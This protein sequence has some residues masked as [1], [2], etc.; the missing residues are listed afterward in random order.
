ML[1]RLA[2][3]FWGQV[4]L[5]GSD[6]PPPASRM[7][8]SVIKS[9]VRSLL[10]ARSA[11]GVPA[12]ETPRGKGLRSQMGPGRLDKILCFGRQ[13]ERGRERQ[14]PKGSMWLNELYWLHPLLVRVGSWGSSGRVLTR[15]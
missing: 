5:R 3:N 12:L 2:S 6:P 8:S 10:Q 4:I 9:C 11:L 15:S 1:S 13:V 7:V 14:A